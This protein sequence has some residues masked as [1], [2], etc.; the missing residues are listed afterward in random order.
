MEQS[1]HL[2][3]VDGADPGDDVVGDVLPARLGEQPV[4]HVRIQGVGRAEAVADAPVVPRGA[5]AAAR[6]AAA[7]AGAAAVAGAV[8][9]A[10]AGAGAVAGAAAGAGAVGGGAMAPPAG[11]PL[12]LS[13]VLDADRCAALLLAPEQSPGTRSDALLAE[14]LGFLPEGQRSVAHARTTLRSPHFRQQLDA[15]TAALA[16]GQVDLRQFGL[17]GAGWGVDAFLEA[18]MRAAD[19]ADTDGGS[20]A[21]QQ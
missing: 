2:P 5:S 14:L 16:Q 21:T 4:A 6:S 8:A 7:G 10:A 20:G 12:S 18:V 15:F 3:L 1:P 17:E 19:K 9:G 11:Q 13:R